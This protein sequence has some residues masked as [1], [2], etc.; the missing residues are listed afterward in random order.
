MHAKLSTRNICKVAGHPHSEHSIAGVQATTQCWADRVAHIDD[1]EAARASC[2]V[3]E[4]AHNIHTIPVS[5]ATDGG[6]EQTD[7]SVELWGRSRRQSSGHRAQQHTPNRPQPPHPRPFQAESFVPSSAGAGRIADINDL[8]PAIA[9]G[10]IGALASDMDADSATL[11]RQAALHHWQDR[12]A[13]IKDLQACAGNIQQVTY[14]LYAF[15]RAGNGRTCKHGR[16]CRVAHQ[17]SPAYDIR[18]HRPAMPLITAFRQPEQDHPLHS[19][20]L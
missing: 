18:S 4:V 20:V 9:S 15:E 2:Q 16:S 11:D 7:L 6:I 5:D 10:K 14:Y 1:L 3:G 12:G 19:A 8:E 13:D 17:G